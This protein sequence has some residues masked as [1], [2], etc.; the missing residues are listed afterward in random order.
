[1]EK[2]QNIGETFLG[3]TFQQ[4]YANRALTAQPGSEK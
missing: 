4:N 3:M 2:T 1:M